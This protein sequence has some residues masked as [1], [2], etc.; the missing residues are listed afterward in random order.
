[1]PYGYV[2][3]GSNID[4]RKHVKASLVAMRQCFGPLEVS[5]IYESEA[6][7]FV[8]ASFYNC[9]V[10]FYSEQ[11]VKDVAKQL[12]QIEIANGRTGSCSKFSSRTLDLDLIL[13]GDWVI[14]DGRLQI[15]RAEIECYAFVLEPL[16]EIAPLLQHPI[17]KIT[18]AVLW[19]RFDKTKVQQQRVNL[20]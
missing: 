17:T 8:G 13:Y 12:R 2:S 1:M 20:D 15:P 18:Y 16:A 7:G 10:G 11:D 5:S 19:Q 9:V 4:K 3:V 14:S 6:V